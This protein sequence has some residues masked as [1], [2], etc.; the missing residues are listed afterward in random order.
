[1]NLVP[2]QGEDGWEWL[3]AP[4]DQTTY[5][6]VLEHISS[7]DVVLEIG[8]G[9]FRL[10]RQM[11]KQTRHVYAVERQKNLLENVVDLPDNCQVIAGDARWVPFPK[12]ITAAV[13]LMRHCTHLA[14]YW[15]KLTLVSCSKLITNARWGMGVEVI[16]LQSP[17]I[18]YEAVGLGWYACWCGHTGFLP[19]EASAITEAMMDKVWEVSECPSCADKRVSINSLR[20]GE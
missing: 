6:A 13:L 19:G 11:A 2:A 9:D 10:A 4:Y 17:R 15:C 16:D 8:A 1:M 12:G 20:R 5:S 7:D 14:L 18:S 3:W